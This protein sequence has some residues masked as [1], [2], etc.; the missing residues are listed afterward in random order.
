MRVGVPQRRS[1]RRSVVTDAAA[2]SGLVTAAMWKSVGGERS[3]E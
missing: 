3:P 1:G 2:V